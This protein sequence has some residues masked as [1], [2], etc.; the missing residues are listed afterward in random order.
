MSV[1][2]TVR[3]Y[4][5][6]GTTSFFYGG[7]L[8]D[9]SSLASGLV[10]IPLTHDPAKGEVYDEVVPGDRAE[11]HVSCFQRGVIRV[12]GRTTELTWVQIEDGNYQTLWVPMAVLRGLASG[13]ARTILPCSHWKWQIQN[14]GSP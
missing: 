11:F 3:A 7:A 12:E 8:M 6:P 13:S 10:G 2:L 9:T 14:F 4:S 1:V 5:S